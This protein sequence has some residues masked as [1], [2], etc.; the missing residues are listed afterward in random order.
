MQLELI[1]LIYNK[2]AKN[3]YTEKDVLQQKLQVGPEQLLW[4]PQSQ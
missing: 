1:Q 2:R 3:K 4:R